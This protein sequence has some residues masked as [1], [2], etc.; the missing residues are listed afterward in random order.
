MYETLL[1]REIGLDRRT[2]EEALLLGHIYNPEDNDEVLFNSTEIDEEDLAN[3][4]LSKAICLNENLEEWGIDHVWRDEDKLYVFISV[5]G[6][7]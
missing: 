3:E 5:R 4:L 6:N 7:G 1:K 2:G